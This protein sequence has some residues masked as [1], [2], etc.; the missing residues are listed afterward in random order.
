MKIAL[1]QINPT[2]GDLRGNARKIIDFAR[3]ASRGRADLV[4]FPELSV[5][6]YPPLDLL[7][8][9]AFID[10]VERSIA[11]IADEIPTGIGV[12][13]GAPVR[14]TDSIGKRLFNSAVLLQ[15]GERLA[16]VHK[17]LLPTYDVYDEYRYF[18]PARTRRCIEFRGL[19]LGIHICEDMWNSD[20]DDLP[21]MYA[22]DPLEELAAEGAD[23]FVNL[24]A[25]PFSAGQHGRREALMKGVCARFRMPI[26]SAN[27]VGANGE[28]IFDGDSRAHMADG[29]LAACAPAFEEALITWDLDDDHASPEPED[30]DDTADL[31]RALVVGIREYCR[32]SGSFDRVLIGLSG[33]IDSAV[34]AALAAEALG[35]SNVLA[36]SMPAKYTTRGSV[37]DARAVAAN[38]SIELREL[39]LDRGL[40]T[41]MEMVNEVTQGKASQAP[42]GGGLGR[43]DGS[44]G[45]VA[46]RAGEAWNKGAA[47]LSGVTIVEENLQARLR[48]VILMAISNDSRRLVLTT[49]NKSELA[50]GYTTLYGDM[51]GG[52]AVLSDVY[53]SRVYDLARHINASAADRVI[54]E[55]IIAKP[56]SAE[57]RPGQTD[58]DSLPPYDVLDSILQLHLEERHGENA[59]VEK[60]GFERSIVRAVICKVKAAEFKRRQ[61]AP[62]LRVT[63]RAFGSGYRMPVVGGWTDDTEH[64]VQHIRSAPAPND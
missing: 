51:A 54:L 43:D 19:R 12:L 53:K 34:T 9:E 38:L 60:T 62:G 52:L 35:A 1:A 31:H 45:A 10:A 50:V 33:G 57:L 4:V 11:R 26:V 13:L 39:P 7:E 36:V 41:L 14:N 64:T 28:L 59:I 25:T 18:E 61:A 44:G 32:K 16:D 55:R 58:Q 37:E 49:G 22:V 46:G 6:G 40:E 2:V 23:V 20:P 30:R 56:P 24:S 21:R 8:Q 29:R 63:R 5:T 17:S 42:G 3:Q 27:Q 15:N 47:A 48:A